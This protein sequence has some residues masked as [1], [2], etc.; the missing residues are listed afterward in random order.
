MEMDHGRPLSWP[1]R[2]IISLRS[3]VL[4]WGPSIQNR[5]EVFRLCPVSSI[6]VVVEL[7]AILLL[8]SIPLRVF[9]LGSGTTPSYPPFSSRLLIKGEYGGKSRRRD[10]RCEGGL[11]AYSWSSW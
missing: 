10:K 1:S 2:P 5:T 4:G 7:V 3:K 6:L 11:R 9:E 8:V